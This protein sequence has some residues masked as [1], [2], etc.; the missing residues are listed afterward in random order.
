VTD[1]GIY[2]STRV[3][4]V[5][6]RARDEVA[7]L[8]DDFAAT[9]SGVQQALLMSADGLLICT[10][11]KT[12]GG[13]DQAAAEAAAAFTATMLGIGRTLAAH[14]AGILVTAGELDRDWHTDGHADQG[15]GQ[16]V[17]QLPWGAYY[18]VGAVGATAGLGVLTRPKA[19]LT[20]ITQ[21]MK[22]LAEG[23][24][25]HLAPGRAGQDGT[26]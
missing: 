8:V 9:T 4:P 15:T 16:M 6:N 14:L 21:A 25:E 22:T 1:L 10:S 24:G 26:A 3:P 18:L 11:G 23:A 5:D 17:H 19:T 12:D 7:R 2:A 13:A 20:P